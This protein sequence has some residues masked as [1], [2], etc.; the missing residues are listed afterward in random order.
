VKITYGV[1]N[2]RRAAAQA[3][4]IGLLAGLP[5]VGLYVGMVNAA[6]GR[7]KKYMD[8]EIISAQLPYEMQECKAERVGESVLAICGR[9]GSPRFAVVRV[10]PDGSAVVRVVVLDGTQYTVSDNEPVRR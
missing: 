8:T 6:E 2:L 1:S 7:P 5:V 3:I 10:A 4:G 9:A